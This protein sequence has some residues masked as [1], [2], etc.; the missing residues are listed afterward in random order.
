LLIGSGGVLGLAPAPE[1]TF[2]IYV[3]PVGCYFKVHLDAP[4]KTQTPKV[5]E[6]KL[7]LHKCSYLMI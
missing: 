5:A 6:K 4:I 7:E 2:V 1:F 3:S